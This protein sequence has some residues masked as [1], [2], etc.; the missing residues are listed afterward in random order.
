MVSGKI[1]RGSMLDVMR[2]NAVVVTGKLGQLQSKKV[3]MEEVAEGS[4]AGLRVDF[5]NKSMTPNLYI[6]E[7]DFLDIYEEERMQ[8][9]I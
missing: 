9:S 4:E 8:R 7:G 5:F 6:R 2:N 1:K 3:D